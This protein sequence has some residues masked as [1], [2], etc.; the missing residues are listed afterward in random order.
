MAI[1][2]G[3]LKCLGNKTWAKTISY[4]VNNNIQKM[5]LNAHKALQ[6]TNDLKITDTYKTTDL[7]M[8]IIYCIQKQ[9]IIKI[10]AKHFN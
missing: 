7:K 9:N 10:F 2:D 5:A 8:L 4:E 6:I 3:I 1:L